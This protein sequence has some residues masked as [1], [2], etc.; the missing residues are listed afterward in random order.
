M[1]NLL[2]IMQTTSSS[3]FSIFITILF[4]LF[5]SLL[6]GKMKLSC[7][8]K[9]YYLKSFLFSAYTFFYSSFHS[10]HLQNKS[11]HTHTNTHRV[12]SSN[13]MN[14]NIIHK[15]GFTQCKANHNNNVLWVVN[16]CK[17]VTV[18]TVGYLD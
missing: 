11:T 7:Y 8:T 5:Y 9:D 13:N 3:A 15:A 2:I 17:S 18:A 14:I 4:F 16:K 10:N 6:L 1:E 12:Y